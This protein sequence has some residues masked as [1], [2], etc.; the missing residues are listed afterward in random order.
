MSV[1][2]L[3]DALVVR[4]LLV[5]SLLTVV[6]PASGWPGP[7]LRRPAGAPATPAPAAPPD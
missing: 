6:G 2:I 3:I 1:G 7:H 4:S 5:P